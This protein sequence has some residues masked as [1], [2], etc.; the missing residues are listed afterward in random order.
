MLIL[1]VTFWENTLCRTLQR[2]VYQLCISHVSNF[3]ILTPFNPILLCTVTSFSPSLLSLARF[4][5]HPE[6]KHRLRLSE[7]LL[8]DECLRIYLQMWHILEAYGPKECYMVQVFSPLGFNYWYMTYFFRHPVSLTSH[9]HSQQ[10]NL[11]MGTITSSSI[12]IFFTLCRI[13]TSRAYTR[14]RER[15]SQ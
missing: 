12:I 14:G 4:R 5:W 6:L 3:N 11:S 2:A 9:Q 8:I 15:L 10:A 13:F 1:L 7:T